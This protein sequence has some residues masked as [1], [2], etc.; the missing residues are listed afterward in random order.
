MKIKSVLITTT[1]V[2]IAGLIVYKLWANKQK[3]NERNKPAESTVLQIPV[4]ADTVKEVEMDVS[5]VKT[6][7]LAAFKEAKVLALNGGNLQQLKFNL[8]DHVVEGQL[9]AVTDTRLNNLELQKAEA[10]AAK[11]KNDLDTYQEL[12]AGNAATQEKVNQ[13]QQD[14]FNAQNQ[15]SQSRKNVSDAIIRAPLSG[16]ISSKPVE[17]GMFVGAGNEIATIVNLSRTKAQVNLTEIEV[18]Q[19]KEKQPVKITTD[20]YPDKV[21]N[22]SISFIS[23]QADQAH[24]YLVEILVDNNDAAPLR[25][26]TFVY[27]D[28]SRKTQTKALSIPREALSES[29]GNTYVYAIKD[30]HVYRKNIRT[31]ADMGASIQV[32]EGIAAGDVIVTSGQINLKDSA[33]VRI[34]P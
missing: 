6:G 28:F 4:K 1:L 24:N 22:G 20:V 17:A 9:L 7:T 23:P 25:S 14:Y 15:V 33:G 19:V 21:F 18:Y 5:L 16:I 31:G 13:L 2:V 3:I 26:G 10:N 27:A 34:T 8:G 12:L 32:L 30:N 11:L 29:A